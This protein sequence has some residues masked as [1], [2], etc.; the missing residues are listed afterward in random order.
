M[1]NIN[2]ETVTGLDIAGWATVNIDIK[3][4]ISGNVFQ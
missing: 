2:I 1:Q 3:V 4:R